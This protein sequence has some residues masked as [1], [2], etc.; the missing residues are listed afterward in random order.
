MSRVMRFIHKN[1][2]P[3]VCLT[4][5]PLLLPTQRRYF[6]VHRQ[7]KSTVMQNNSR[8]VDT[9]C[10]IPNILQKFNL[11]VTPETFLDFKQKHFG[12]QFEKCVSVASDAASQK[13]TAD[14]MANVECISG[15]F[16]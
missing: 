1:H 9:H 6:V 3:R 16:G 4:K 8:F 7:S 2:T 5:H 13:A 10:N 14:L 15:A 12:D 11:E